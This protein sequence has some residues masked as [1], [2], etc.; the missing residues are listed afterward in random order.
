MSSSEAGRV[1]PTPRGRVLADETV[2]VSEVE[3]VFEE[4][5]TLVLGSL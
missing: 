5:L 1:L 2:L 4:D 3:V